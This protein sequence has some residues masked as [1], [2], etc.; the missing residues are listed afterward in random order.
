V[1]GSACALVVALAGCGSSSKKSSST[2]TTSTPAK[3]TTTTTAATASPQP[4]A[5]AVASPTGAVAPSQAS[6]AKLK[7]VAKG[8]AVKAH[9]AGLGKLPLSQAVQEASGDINHFW[10]QE[11]ASS[12]IQWPQ[13]QDAIVDSQ[14][15]QTQCTS[16]R[17]TVAPTDPWYLCDGQS[18]GTYYWTIPWMQR[19][20]ATDSGGVNLVF[21][22]AE[23]WAF[24]IQ[25]MFGFT[26]KLQQG[27]LSKGQWAQQTVCLTGIYARSLNDRKL[28]EQ[29]DQQAVQSFLGALSN[30]NGITAPDVSAQQLQQVFVAGF[31]S[32]QPSTCGIAAGGGG[33]GGSTT[34]TTTTPTPTPTSPTP[35]SQGPVSPL[36]GQTTT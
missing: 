31:N 24:H 13:M 7:A 21:S 8:A 34:N 28:F 1:L 16:G 19:N 33:G 12:G 25:N 3:T 30:V 29:G 2:A 26:D 17:A 14:P 22:M 10:S 36:P 23:M 35:T 15:V 27:Q 9:L 11:F 5:G 4:I 20:I 32:G 6:L 18:G